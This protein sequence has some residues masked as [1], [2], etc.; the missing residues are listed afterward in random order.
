MN[1]DINFKLSE[2]DEA[3]AYLMLPGHSGAGIFGAVAKQV[4]LSTILDYKG[5]DIYLDLDENGRL[6][7]I[8][9]LA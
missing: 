9:I 4:Q 6:V 8:E 2:D 5:A 1:N 3:V 7:G